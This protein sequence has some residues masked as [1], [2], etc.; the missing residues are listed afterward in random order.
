MRPS[1]DVLARN[2]MPLWKKAV[3]LRRDILRAR[4]QI[5]H[6]LLNSVYTGG[7]G[8]EPCV[9]RTARLAI[10]VCAEL[11]RGCDQKIRHYM[12][13]LNGVEGFRARPFAAGTG[14]TPPAARHGGHLRSVT[15]VKTRGA[16]PWWRRSLM[17]AA[18]RVEAW[19]SGHR[20]TLADRI[21]DVAATVE[22]SL[23]DAE[24]NAWVSMRMAQDAVVELA[25][26]T[27]D[28]V[29]VDALLRAWPHVEAYRKQLGA[30]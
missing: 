2:V 23:F 17:R 19:L 21:L 6:L 26:Q 1:P 8:L 12:Q 29:V 27:Y 30:A 9:E 18:W 11:E 3:R 5:L 22:G 16:D 14:V 24:E 28:P 10:I 20:R 13:L 4:Q 7:A 15:Q 25:G